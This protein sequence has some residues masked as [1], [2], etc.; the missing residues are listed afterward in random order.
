M[1]WIK[2]FN[3]RYIRDSLQYSLI[4]NVAMMKV[5]RCTY[6]STAWAD[7]STELYIL[8]EDMASM[9]SLFPC[10]QTEIIIS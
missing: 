9:L 5:K 3:Q 2:F 4:I 8:Y 6:I 1:L 7:F 10:D